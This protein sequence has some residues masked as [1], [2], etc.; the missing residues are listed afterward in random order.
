M[1]R[2]TAGAG[3]FI[4]SFLIAIPQGL[5]ED[6]V[7]VIIERVEQ[8]ECVDE[9][10]WWCGS[11][12]DFYAKVTL[13]GTSF[14]SNSIGDDADISPNWSFRHTVS[15]RRIPIRLE[16]WDSD[17]GLRFGDD[18]VDITSGSGR[19]LDVNLNLDSCAITGGVSGTCGATLVS[20]GT[21][22]DRAR[23]HFRIEVT[24]VRLGEV[25]VIG[26][27]LTTLECVDDFLWWCGS[28]A[29][30][31]GRIGIDG[32]EQSN[33]G[34]N[35]STQFG[36]QDDD[37]AYWRFTRWV[38]LNRATLPLSVRIMD[39]DG[40]LNPDDTVDI[41]PG[42][43]R[44]LELDLNPASCVISGEATGRCGGL[45]DVN[46]RI[47]VSGNQSD[48][49]RMQ[50]R[51]QVY[52]SPRVYVRCLHSPIW[53]QPGDTVTFSAE[54]L[55][56]NMRPIVA[57]RI[58]LRQPATGAGTVHTCE[59][60]S[61][62]EVHLNA[63]TSGTFNYSCLAE[64]RG[65]ATTT[66]SRGS[67][68]GTPARGRAVAVLQHQ[69]TDRAMDF[70]FIPDSDNY[71]SA[72]DLSFRNDVYGVIWTAFLSDELF[73]RNQD[74]FNFWIAQDRGDAHGFTTGS[75]CYTP[76]ANWTT[77]YPFADSGVLLHTD[78]LRDCAT[79]GI[80]SSE[81]GSTETVRH[82]TGHSPFG[83]ADEYCCDGGYFQTS[84]NPNLFGPEPPG[85]TAALTACQ[86]DPLAGLRDSC[87]GFVS[88][89]ISSGNQFF[90]VDHA[91][92]SREVEVEN[93]RM[94]DNKVPRAADDR[95]IQAIIDA[96][97]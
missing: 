9:T 72:N 57:D 59:N 68:I 32:M 13:D 88:S 34:R 90:R 8:L 6:E 24:P 63:T 55:D 44:V 83:L 77:D 25:E 93:D 81:P 65:V 92:A 67:T 10:L 73:L 78:D 71:A 35:E 40:F 58:A 66:G 82:E 48:R 47:D 42:A 95:R 76:P 94:I 38:N 54:A 28:A 79:G 70:V 52:D 39:S 11:A 30:Y 31:Y 60:A 91:P 20:S 37:A 23:I 16:I 45:L 1:L 49:A 51:I 2:Y 14:Q 41:Q 26:E 21:S 4:L 5:T 53:P 15:S 12:G 19:N 69:T 87:L 56:A 50:L 97:P 27:R 86:A 46:S 17:G 80:F 89:R 85:S 22:D 36:N 18:H 61:T 33:E 84:V 75:P 74:R 43:G 29:D 64:E 7:T 96:L 3:I 62:C